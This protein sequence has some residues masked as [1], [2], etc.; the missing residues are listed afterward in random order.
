MTSEQVRQR[1]WKSVDNLVR[2]TLGPTLVQ[3][4]RQTEPPIRYRVELGVWL[5]L[6]VLAA[7]RAEAIKTVLDAKEE[8]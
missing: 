1:L 2:C 4:R 8:R 5:D 3:I 7:V 6:L